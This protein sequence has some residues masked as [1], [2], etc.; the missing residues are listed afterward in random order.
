M[1][2]RKGLFNRKPPVISPR[3]LDAQVLVLKFAHL[4]EALRD[5]KAELLVSRIS[6]VPDLTDADKLQYNLTVIWLEDR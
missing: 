6:K 4:A 5:G 2:K 3:D 1:K